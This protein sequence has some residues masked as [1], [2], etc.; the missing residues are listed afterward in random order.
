MALPVIG[1][2]L[3]IGERLIDKLIPDPKAK[4]DALQKLAEL[5]QSG[6]L[7]VMQGQ[8]EIN[9]IE[10][11]NSDRFVSGWRP[12]IGWVCGGGMVMA[13]IVSPLVQLIISIVGVFKGQPFVAPEVDMTT[14]MPILTAM[15]GMAGLRTFEK[16][17]DVE[18]N[19]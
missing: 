3:S 7:A 17:H 2:L 12:G 19:R 18:K 8:M 1:A 6:D 9:K 4:A 15:L 13:Y 11:A 16:Y 5:E 14:L 10:A